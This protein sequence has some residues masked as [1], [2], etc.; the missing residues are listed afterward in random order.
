MIF[1]Y[2]DQYQAL[3][4]REP[5]ACRADRPEGYRLTAVKAE[6]GSIR[7]LNGDTTHFYGLID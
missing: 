2:V 5:W 6:Q 4:L 1:I 7:V 3:P